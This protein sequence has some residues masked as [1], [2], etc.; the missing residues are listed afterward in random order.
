MKYRVDPVTGCW[1]WREAL[2]DYGYG[3][4][5]L[6][7]RQVLA[8]RAMYQ[9]HVGSVPAGHELHHTCRNRSCVNPSHLVPLNRDL[10]GATRRKPAV[11]AIGRILDSQNVSVRRL[12]A[13][14][15]VRERTVYRHVRGETRV[16]LKSAAAYARAL[17][18][19]LSELVETAA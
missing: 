4:T 3:V 9:L 14:S 8:H 10:H 6:D 15:G 1:I 2:N 5:Y 7:D 18:V 16:D 12:A 11:T 17:K 19:D 13:E